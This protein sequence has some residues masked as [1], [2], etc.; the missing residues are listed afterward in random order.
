MTVADDSRG[1][2]AAPIT[3]RLIKSIFLVLYRKALLL[4]T[5]STTSPGLPCV[6]VDIHSVLI[7]LSFSTTWFY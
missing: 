5:F 2:K 1:I 3:K 7:P 4:L 6:L